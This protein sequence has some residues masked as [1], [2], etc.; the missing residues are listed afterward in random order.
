MKPFK[1][2][3]ISNLTIILL[4]IASIFGGMVISSAQSS[5]EQDPA[6][7]VEDTYVPQ[8]K[9]GIKPEGQPKSTGEEKAPA[10]KAKPSEQKRKSSVKRSQDPSN[11]DAPTA[12]DVRAAKQAQGLKGYFFQD[13]K[14]KKYFLQD[15]D[16]NMYK[17]VN[18]AWVKIKD[19]E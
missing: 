6:I 19:A 16:G 17:F 10:K 2:N 4:F 7:A 13:S 14:S 9:E 15:F 12:A 3:Y 8:P 18:N 11:P 1:M 5:E